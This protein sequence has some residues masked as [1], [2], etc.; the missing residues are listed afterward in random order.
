[1]PKQEI[2]PVIGRQTDPGHLINTRHGSPNR[3][4]LRT[5]PGEFSSL[6]IDRKPKASTKITT[7]FDGLQ[8][9][10]VHRPDGSWSKTY[11]PFPGYEMPSIEPVVPISQT[12]P[13]E[14]SE[15]VR[16]PVQPRVVLKDN[17]VDR[18]T[19]WIMGSRVAKLFGVGTAA[20]GVLVGGA[21]CGS[22]PEP[23]PPPAIVT[24]AEARPTLTVSIPSSPTT[25]VKQT[26]AP[27]VK[28]SPS[29]TTG[30]EIG[31]GLEIGIGGEG[32]GNELAKILSGKTQF[33]KEIS[34]T[35][36]E[37]ANPGMN[38]IT[39]VDHSGVELPQHPQNYLDKDGKTV[40][41][42]NPIIPQMVDIK[43]YP[44]RLGF[45][46]KGSVVVYFDGSNWNYHVPITAPRENAFLVVYLK[47]GKYYQGF[48]DGNNKIIPNTEKEYWQ[49]YKDGISKVQLTQQG[50]TVF[51]TEWIKGD[52]LVS[53]EIILKISQ[54]V[55][56][57]PSPN[58]EATKAAAGKIPEPTR[59]PSQEMLNRKRLL[60][61]LDGKPIPLGVIES[62]W[63]PTGRHKV[64]LSGFITKGVWEEN[65]DL[66][67][68][69][70]VPSEADPLKEVEM[71]VFLAR[72]SDTTII[73]S[74]RIAG[75]RKVN[76]GAMSWSSATTKEIP[77]LLV[78]G[79]QVIVD[80]YDEMT[81]S[82]F[83]SIKNG[84]NCNDLCRQRLDSYAQYIPYTKTTIDAIKSAS[85]VE[86]VYPAGPGYQIIIGQD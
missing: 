15:N 69:L 63:L 1:M 43:K 60:N 83:E 75:G 52:V 22:T 3:L 54:P 28:P 41:A 79:D 33:K 36:F 18:F 35:D 14:V 29:P 13:I 48:M 46:P 81:S 59:T 72:A 58:A 77:N 4:I 76:S 49:R 86:K 27:D 39:P 9:T 2:E 10:T 57:S 64:S 78:K 84:P 50:D 47:G 85:P 65:G 25:E 66:F 80:M 31:I 23:T 30:M 62:F 12:V 67:F 21:A 24:P 19:N 71:K 32:A 70:A 17:V 53:S 68:G 61:L 7:R 16:Q 20:G 51:T 82:A 11:N 40:I 38:L 5:M 8:T 37:K 56:P 26:V 42:F 45:D 74:Y 44:E 73:I 6:H 34:R 55:T